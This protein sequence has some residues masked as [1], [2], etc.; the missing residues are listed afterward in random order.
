MKNESPEFTYRSSRSS[1]PEAKGKKREKPSSDK[2]STTSNSNRAKRRLTKV[3]THN[4]SLSVEELL[5]EKN[6]SLFTQYQ[7]T[8]P[9]LRQDLIKLQSKR[10]LSS[11]SLLELQKK[12][13][14]I[15]Q[16]RDSILY[17]LRLAQLLRVFFER[18]HTKLNIS[19]AVL[20]LIDQT[21]IVCEDW[22][23]EWTLHPDTFRPTADMIHN[24]HESLLVLTQLLI[25]YQHELFPHSVE[26]RLDSIRILSRAVPIIHKTL[27]DVYIWWFAPTQNSLILIQ[28]DICEQCHSGLL[29]QRRDSMQTCKCSARTYHYFNMIQ[30]H[31]DYKHEHITTPHEYKRTQFIQRWLTQFK[32][33]SR[34]VEFSV[35]KSVKRE[36]MNRQ[37]TSKFDVKMTTVKGVLSRLGLQQYQPA[38]IANMLNDIPIAEFT[39]EQFE[40]ILERAKAV[41]EVHLYLKQNA[42]ILHHQIKRVNFPSLTYFVR[43]CCLINKWHDLSRRFRLHKLEVSR[44]RQEDEWKIF[45]RYLKE[46]DPHHKWVFIRTK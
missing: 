2:G 30:S 18:T 36:L 8:L 22:E 38:K 25:Q 6:R 44:E 5:E 43:Q 41:E 35:L 12:I 29:F 37:I 11:Q 16:C 14:Y 17:L 32:E 26:S 31:S 21:T 34:K 4:V 46:R 24:C 3:Q 40:E 28:K 39:E 23:R 7:V 20:Q 1:M 9:T 27:G 19:L 45:I 42:H 15:E 33:G 13:R 10:R